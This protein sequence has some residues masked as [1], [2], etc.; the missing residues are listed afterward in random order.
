MPKWKRKKGL[1]RKEK[2]P[3]GNSLPD[4]GTQWLNEE[5]S[6]DP[7]DHSAVPQGLKG[8]S[9][10]DAIAWIHSNCKF[11]TAFVDETRLTSEAQQ[12]V[13]QYQQSILAFYKE[14]QVIANLVRGGQLQNAIPK[15]QQL[16]G[17]LKGLAQFG[18]K[19]DQIIGSADKMNELLRNFN[20]VGFILNFK[21]E[22]LSGRPAFTETPPNIEKGPSGVRPEQIVSSIDNKFKDFQNVKSFRMHAQGIAEGLEQLI[23]IINSGTM[24]TQQP[25]MPGAMP[26]I[27]P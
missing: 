25:T 24:P 4:D 5:K 15:I 16:S 21:E 13:Q 11:V 7:S 17:K 3:V 8:M 2:A 14:W 10:M 1:D 19:L 26:G 23:R 12:G 22:F 6:R 18:A 9:G 27:M 20:P